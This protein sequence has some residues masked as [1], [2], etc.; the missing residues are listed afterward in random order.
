MTKRIA[1]DQDQVVA[2]ILQEWLRR[3]NYD[4][5]DTLTPEQIV[6][7]NWDHIVKPECGKKI[8]TYLDDPELFA[9]LQL[10][11]ESQE[12]I[13][14]L[15]KNYEIFFVTAPFNP[16]NVVPKHEWLRRYF[17]FVPERNYVF[18][19]NK[20]IVRA[21]W[22]IDD[23][24]GNFIDFYGEGLLF[25]APHNQKYTGEE[26][27]FYNWQEIVFYFDYMKNIVAEE[28]NHEAARQVG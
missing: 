4:Y 2:D 9:N 15:S 21:N 12:A 17:S 20:S 13:Y 28:L 10:I 8:Y 3:Y 1:I 6:E 5:N 24:P 14:E 26:R 11:D 16:N 7:W 27:R 18:T 25:D 23:K 19:R 22:L